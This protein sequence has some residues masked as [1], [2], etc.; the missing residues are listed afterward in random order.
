MRLYPH[1]HC[2]PVKSELAYRVPLKPKSAYRKLFIDLY[3][4]CGL[5]FLLSV[6]DY[7]YL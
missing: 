5:F 2:V 7:K 1:A 4:A 6:F 3:H